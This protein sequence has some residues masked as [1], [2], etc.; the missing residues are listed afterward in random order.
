MFKL[1]TLALLVV[2]VS[3]AV[4]NTTITQ[5]DDDNPACWTEKGIWGPQLLEWALG[6]KNN[7]YNLIYFSSN[8]HEKKSKYFTKI[9]SFLGK[10]E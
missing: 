10:V 2:S 4:L 5:E 3:C 7:R 8:F 9:V 6:H 1:S